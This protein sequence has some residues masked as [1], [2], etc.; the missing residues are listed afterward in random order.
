MSCYHYLKCS[1]R[2]NPHRLM[3]DVEIAEGIVLTPE[4]LHRLLNAFNVRMSFIA[5]LQFLNQD[6]RV[7]R[8]HVEGQLFPGIAVV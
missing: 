2:D 6:H 5:G 8:A 4:E 7:D 3:G 1:I